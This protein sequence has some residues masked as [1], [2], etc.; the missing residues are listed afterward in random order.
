MRKMFNNNRSI[1][2]ALILAGLLPLLLGAACAGSGS[3][4]PPTATGEPAATMPPE[5]T[6]TAVDTVLSLEALGNATYQGISDQPVTLIGGRFEGPPFE[7]GGAS[8]PV[9]TMLAEQI[10]LGD[11]NGD[12]GEEAAVVLA[13]NSGGSGTFVYLS[14]VESA[15]GGLVNAA[16]T[17]LGDRVQVSALTIEDG[18]I[19]VTLLSHGAADPAC[20]PTLETTRIYE[21]QGDQLIEVV[22]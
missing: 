21:L 9:I 16:T 18:Q 11:L 12:E 6:P 3:Q 19:L 5:S 7:E 17:L 13:S 20:C 10:A 4:V 1:A 8:R 15:G 2:A 22:E 14:A